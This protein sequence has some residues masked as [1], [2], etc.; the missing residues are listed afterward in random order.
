MSGTVSKYYTMHHFRVQ[1]GSDHTKHLLEDAVLAPMFDVT[2]NAISEAFTKREFGSFG[3]TDAMFLD[4]AGH[5]KR[6]QWVCVVDGL[7]VRMTP[8]YTDMNVVSNVPI[9]MA[10]N[11]LVEGDDQRVNALLIKLGAF[12]RQ[13]MATITFAVMREEAAIRLRRHRSDLISQ[14]VRAFYKVNG[15]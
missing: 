13:Y 10:W 5:F 8:V 15:M 4:R 3:V 7:L 9:Y 2:W 1:C 6:G 11:I 14:H 12:V